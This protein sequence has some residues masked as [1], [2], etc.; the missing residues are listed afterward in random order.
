MARS[1]GGCHRDAV[2]L[3]WGPPSRTFQGSK[4]GRR[5]ER[6]DYAGM[7]AVYTNNFYGSYGYWPYGPRSRYACYGIG[8]EVTYLPYRIASVWFLDN[9]VDAWERAR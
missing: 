1:S 2:Y 6:W 4:N 7:R 9:R 8:P 3:A 5:T